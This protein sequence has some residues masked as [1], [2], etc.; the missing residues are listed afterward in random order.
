VNWIFTDGIAPCLAIMIR[1]YT[2][3]G[4]LEDVCYAFKTANLPISKILFN[5]TRTSMDQE[6][7]D[8]YVDVRIDNAG[9]FYMKD[10][11]KAD[12]KW[13]KILSN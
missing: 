6:V 8:N 12:P 1:G 9:N 13:Q 4:N 7:G 3:K 11:S 5:P 2:Q 10:A